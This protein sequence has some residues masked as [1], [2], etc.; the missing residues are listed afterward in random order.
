MS[1]H[2][3]VTREAVTAA[4]ADDPVP[5]IARPDPIPAL[6]GLRIF[7]ALWVVL[8]HLQGTLYA[9]WGGFRLFEPLLRYG[10]NGV[11]L[12]FILSG[13]IIWHNYGRRDLLHPRATVR[14]MWRRFARLWPVN[15]AAQLLTVPLIWWT[16]TVTHYWDT[17]TPAWYAIGGWF[18]SAFMAGVAGSPFLVTFPWDQPAWTL[19]GEMAAYL[20]FPVILALALVTRLHHG[21]HGWIFIPVALVIAYE[22]NFFG[23]GQQIPYSW[24]INLILMFV[25]GV[26]LRVAGRPLRLP[27]IPAVIQIAAPF[28][29]VV[30]CYL[31]QNT[32]LVPLMALWVW[33]LAAPSGP[34][35]RLLSTRPFQIAGLASYSLYMLHWVIFGFGTIWVFYAVPSSAALRVYVVV[36]LLIVA[37]ASWATW[38]FFESPSRGLL[39][40]LFERVWRARPPAGVPASRSTDS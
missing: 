27:Q 31:G 10:Y 15:V 19:T 28:A 29:I 38:R 22:T 12:F 6:T 14:F 4:L 1:V 8:F 39:N 5:T 3:E 25:V 26:V 11:P 16:V 20:V 30:S 13:Y 37:G 34:G 24:A 35:V 33:A 40:R 7:G 32:L 18:Q 36:V 17:P 9:S 21:R 2:D 23:L